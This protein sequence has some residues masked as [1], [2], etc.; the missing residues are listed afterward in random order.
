MQTLWP[1][2][3]APVICLPPAHLTILSLC[4]SFLVLYRLV[5]LEACKGPKQAKSFALFRTLAP[6]LHV[7]GPPQSRASHF[8]REAFVSTHAPGTHCPMPCSLTS[9][10]FMRGNSLLYW[11]ASMCSAFLPGRWALGRDY[12]CLHTIIHSSP[13]TADTQWILE[14]MNEWSVQWI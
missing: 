6:C 8:F 7:V 11:F 13:G 5:M 3:G 4:P 2:R 10:H 14:G 12:L 9:L 1:I